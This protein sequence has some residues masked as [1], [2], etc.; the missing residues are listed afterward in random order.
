MIL[1]PEYL[2]LT[3]S[4]R[5][6]LLLQKIQKIVKKNVTFFL[7]LRFIVKTFEASG[8]AAGL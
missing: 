4:R 7:L 5:F 3:K 1:N 6:F 2:F 8:P